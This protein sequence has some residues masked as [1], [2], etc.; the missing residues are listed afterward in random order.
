MNDETKAT[1]LKLRRD[2]APLA[3]IASRF[4]LTVSQVGNHCR[5]AGVLLGRTRFSVETRSEILTFRLEGKTSREIAAR[6]GLKVRQISELCYRT[7]AP[8]RNMLK[9]IAAQVLE[10]R[11]Q[12]VPHKLIAQQLG[13]SYI[14]S[15]N[16]VRLH[17]R[18]LL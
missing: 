18:G 15:E 14:T 9:T 12:K 13:I 16:V 8:K 17:N 11:A 2:G 1:V 10:L 5:R 4:G 6:L 3:D 7:G